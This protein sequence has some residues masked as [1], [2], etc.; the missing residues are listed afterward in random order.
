[1]FVEPARPEP[2]KRFWVANGL[3]VDKIWLDCSREAGGNGGKFSS[4]F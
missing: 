2:A 4:K 1:M 3:L